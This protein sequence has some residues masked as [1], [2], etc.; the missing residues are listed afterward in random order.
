VLK[1]NFSGSLAPQ[2]SDWENKFFRL[3]SDELKIGASRDEAMGEHG[4]VLLVSDITAVDRVDVNS[5]AITSAALGGARL[6]LKSP[7]AAGYKQWLDAFCKARG[8]PVPPQSA[9][10]A[11]GPR[12]PLDGD[13]KPAVVAASVA[14]AA[15]S[16]AS[17]PAAP[18]PLE[19]R[20]ANE[21]GSTALG[22][23]MVGICAIVLA[24]FLLGSSSEHAHDAMYKVEPDLRRRSAGVF[25]QLKEDDSMSVIG[26]LASLV[27]SC[28]AGAVG[29]GVYLKVPTSAVVG[30]AG[31]SLG[32]L[33]SRD[34][35]GI[36]VGDV[37]DEASALGV[38]RGWRIRQIASLPVGKE[39]TYDEVVNMI[40]SQPRPLFVTFEETNPERSA[41]GSSLIVRGLTIGL[42]TLVVFSGWI[43]PAPKP[44]EAPKNFVRVDPNGAHAAQ[45][46]GGWSGTLL[47]GAIV[48]ALVLAAAA[49]GRKA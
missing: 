30:F 36:V 19:T 46:G 49:Q 13:V 25:V 3:S 45:A 15:A 20:E 44:P 9:E 5:F 11:A 1:P 6:V 4:L 32:F 28:C 35:D 47:V 41:T 24:W 22:A 29:L 26:I 23:V 10:F 40:R 12:A 21:G 43:W 48:G 16:A 8:I 38:K 34:D 33:V 2:P 37:S 14:S 31:S 27:V 18:P 42:G 39:A 17:S 7:T